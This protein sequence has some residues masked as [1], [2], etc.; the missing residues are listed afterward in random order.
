M[1]KFSF[2][3]KWNI[4]L[5]LVIILCGIAF[6]VGFNIGAMTTTPSQMPPPT[7]P[8][9]PKP[10]FL[11][12]PPKPNI[13]VKI[14]RDYSENI[15]GVYGHEFGMFK[16]SNGTVAILISSRE[17][18]QQN[19]TIEIFSGNL[20]S[21]I[22]IER[23]SKNATL[24]QND[25]VGFLVDIVVPKETNFDEYVVVVNLRNTSWREGSKDWWS[26]SQSLFLRV[27]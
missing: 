27:I 26:Y 25:A 23:V 9:E 1:G 22:Y 20:D 13:T 4:N 15:F 11:P 8:T 5:F 21:D 3:V 16:G 17:A 2:L 6:C 10:T 19:I 18:E 24:A 7:I 12:P 14:D